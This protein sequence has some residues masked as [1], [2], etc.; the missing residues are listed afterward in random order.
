MRATRGSFLTIFGL[1]AVLSLSD[2]ASAHT[3]SFSTSLSISRS[4]RGTVEPGTKVTFSG[5]LSSEKKA[6]KNGSKIQL[7]R[8]GEGVVATHRTDDR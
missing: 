4:P 2:V 6:C 7:I 8:V 1:V 5:R 3:V